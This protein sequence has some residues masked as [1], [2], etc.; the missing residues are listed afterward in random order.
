MADFVMPVSYSDLIGGKVKFEA[1]WIQFPNFTRC[2]G[3]FL[4]WG[5]IA[6]PASF[7]GFHSLHKWVLPWTD[8][9]KDYIG[10]H[11]SSLQLTPWSPP[12]DLFYCNTHSVCH[13]CLWWANSHFNSNHPAN[14]RGNNYRI[15][16]Q[17]APQITFIGD[18]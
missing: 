12:N 16:K 8:P 15:L 7:H 13:L 18:P 10:S 4:H 11:T 6:T 5:T 14:R 1:E 9:W 2:T 3:R 17:M